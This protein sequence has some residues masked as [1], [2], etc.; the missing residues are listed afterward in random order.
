MTEPKPKPEPKVWVSKRPQGSISW[1]CFMLYAEFCTNSKNNDALN[2]CSCSA[3]RRAMLLGFWS[4]SPHPHHVNKRFM[5][6]LRDP[7]REWPWDGQIK[8]KN[9]DRQEP[10][11]SWKLII[12]QNSLWSVTRS[13]L[14][15]SNNHTSSSGRLVDTFSCTKSTPNLKG[16]HTFGYHS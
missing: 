15:I 2:K 10:Q 3:V 7:S 4:S 1:H 5:L 6:H 12:H 11:T 9:S 16:R 13:N 8:I 14:L